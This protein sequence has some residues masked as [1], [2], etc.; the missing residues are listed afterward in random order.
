MA[1]KFLEIV[2]KWSERGLHL[3]RVYRK[4]QDRELFLRAYGKLYANKGATTKGVDP[5]DTIDGMSLERI[6][7]IIEKL[8][9]GTYQ[10]QPVRRTEIP[11]KNR[12]KVRPIGI[13]VWSD[14]LLQEV[15]R[16]VLEAYYEPRFSQYSHGFRPGRGCHT[17]LQEVYTTW[18]G[19]KWFIEGDIQSFFDEID[20]EILLN[21]I[22]RDIKDKKFLKLLKGM[23][24]A[25]YMQD[26]KYHKT[27]SGTPQGNGAS[28]IL[29]NVMLNE[30]DQFVEKELLPQYNRGQKRRPNP[31]YQHLAYEMRKAKAAG[32][33]E[34][35]QQLKR[36][37]Q[38]IPSV[39]PYDPNYSR[40]K[41]IRY[42]DDFL[43]GFTGSRR[44]ALEIKQKIRTFLNI[45]KLT[46]S[47]EK[48][49]I[50]HAT[51]E[52][53]RFLGYE[54]Y[55]GRD[56]TKLTSNKNQAKR[57]L[58]SLN[59]KVILSVPKDV[60]KEWQNRFTKK[61]KPIHRPYLLNCSDYE[62]IQTY[63]L[64]FQGVVN[65]YS[66]AHNVSTMLYPVKYY[67]LQSLVKTLAAKHKKKT[68]W[69][70]RKY[71]RK[72]EH[73]VKALIMEI[74][75]PNN[76]DKPLKAKFGDKPIRFNPNTVIKD[77]IAQH[78]HGRNELVR[79]LL[80]NECELCGASEKIQVHH[81][82]K[83]KDVK[84]KYQ[85]R[86]KPPAWAK[87]MMTRHRKTVVVCHQCH[88][89]IHAGKYDGKRVD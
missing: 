13:S 2:G 27:Y 56:D 86:R 44:E 10:W 5:E 88:V 58:R 1:Q 20:N 19:T 51:K 57:K 72:S 65:Y 43:L 49:L 29:A 74:P 23:L 11:K 33:R 37:K 42:G 89:E 9:N 28:P 24:Q 63:G 76:P 35:Y 7:K 31:Q 50:T 77:S 53:A 25:G 54:I 36:Q 59:G 45:L 30:L 16:M 62:I 47:E 67:Y 70:Y 41:Y 83:L 18:Q 61:G 34:R 8:R 68:G 48:T 39:D 22:G 60:A 4:L 40:L 15:I 52:R 32:D 85:G 87:F 21:I 3:E 84:K 79:R 71:A 26:W 64:E 66:M 80:A 12:N 38:S 14:K 75:N 46:L 73:G 82:R 6:D 17:V 78:Y 69:V 81:V 55:I